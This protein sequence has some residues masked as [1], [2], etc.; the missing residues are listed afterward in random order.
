METLTADDTKRSLDFLTYNKIEHYL[1]ITGKSDLYDFLGVAQNASANALQSAVITAY[2]TTAG[3]TDPKSKA[4]NYLC[5][6]AKSI[7][8]KDENSKKSYDVYL[9]TKDIWAEFALRRSCGFPEMELKEFLRYSE[10]AKKAL[11]NS[12]V[13]IERLLAEGLNS[14]RIAVIGREQ[15]MLNGDNAAIDIPDDCDAN[16]AIAEKSAK[17]YGLLA[18]RHDGVKAVGNVI[19]KGT[20]KPIHVEREFVTSCANQTTVNLQVYENDSSEE[21]AAI[22][23][24]VLMYESCEIELTPGLPEGAPI[25]IIFDLDVN[26]VLEITAIDLTNNEPMNVSAVRTGSES[27]AVQIGAVIQRLECFLARQSNL[28]IDIQTELNSLKNLLP[29]HKKRE[30]QELTNK[31]CEPEKENKTVKGKKIGVDLGTIYAK[32][33]YVDGG[34]VKIIENSEGDLSTPCAV[35][36]AENGEITVG[37]TALQEGG[38]KPDRVV[39][40]VK[41]FIGDP[42]FT[43]TFDGK[44]Y[45]SSDVL[46][47]IFRKLVRDARF[48]LGEE[49]NGAVITCPAY[50]DETARAAIKAAGE[51]AGLNVLKILDEPMAAG[52]AYG[53]SRNENMQ[54]TVLIYHL[55]GAF[56][57]TV[58]KIDFKGN[59]R[60]ME[61]IA[62]GGDHQLGG[63][64]WDARLADY[65]RNEFARRKGIYVDDMENDLESRAWFY[66]NMEK[67]K[68]NLTGKNTAVLTV[69][70]NGEKE[71]IEITRETFDSITVELLERTIL[72]VDEM[73]FRKGLSMADDIDEIIL[74][75]GSARMPQVQQRLE[76]VYNKP[77][78][79][80]EPDKIVAMGAAIMADNIN[81]DVI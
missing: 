70:F 69:S 28:I 39:E 33:S 56:D 34:T 81:I 43:I 36:F 72:L 5:G 25:K 65:V 35:Y 20:D 54:K 80:F 10:I 67:T 15:I 74:V 11:K 61:V 22:D 59:S 76:Q 45:S 12:D 32:M 6:Y 50:F 46:A 13:D 14:Y 2:N 42:S 40:R 51:A 27:H 78:S 19:F 24:S 37:S 1:K 31:S 47:I 16:M 68:K 17:S 71:R 48:Y 62:I 44:D 60:K 66:E 79:S 7:F 55:G 75:G 29:N 23:E 64:D 8:F 73:L 26:G 21:E 41:Y 18:V 52:L 53:N 58:L 3:K 57:C 4:V 63:K 38:L 9:A 49:I 30:R 77:I